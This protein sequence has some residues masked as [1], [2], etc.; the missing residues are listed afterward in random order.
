MGTAGEE[1]AEELIHRVAHG[2]YVAFVGGTAG[3]ALA[4][5][6]Q[7]PLARVLGAAAYGQFYLGVNLLTT[8]QW[9]ASLGLDWGVIRF[10]AQYRGAGD[11]RRVK[12]TL[13]S[14]VFI[15]M[16]S[17]T[18][19]AVLCIVFSGTLAGRVFHDPP[20]GRV[21]GMFALA[22]PFLALL[23]ITA[24]FAQSFH[25][26]FYM[27]ILQD[28]SQ[29]GITFLLVLL[30]LALGWGLTGAVFSVVAA[31]AA[32]ATLGSFLIF[33]LFPKIASPLAAIFSVRSL[34]RYSIPLM[35]LG[36]AWQFASR[37]DLWM[38]EYFV[39]ARAVGVYGAAATSALVLN[40]GMT[41]FAQ[42]TAPMMADLYHRRNLAELRWLFHTITRW[43]IVIVLSM[44]PVILILSAEIMRLFGREFDAGVMVLWLLALS[45]VVYFA[46]GPTAALMDM[47]GWQDLDLVNTVATGAVL[48]GLGVWLIPRYG[49]MGAAAA[50]SVSRVLLAVAE[51]VETYVLFKV[52]PFDARS[53]RP[54]GV[55]ALVAVVQVIALP[56]VGRFIVAG[57]GFGVY[58]LLGWRMCLSDHDRSV[59]K[60]VWRRV[61]APGVASVEGP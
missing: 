21:F 9:V 23:R 12:G 10:C 26:M 39:G 22:L 56:H 5:A 46:K 43:N 2:A 60:S 32:S 58:W 53:L 31:S 35:L 24:M 14:A 49:L 50:T 20:L 37:F 13:L 17:S 45:W 7:V 16:A 11:E 44:L 48:V 51:S 34:L 33:R 57:A 52:L 59:V 40:T 47:T 4:F 15:A 19:I 30:T 28:V 6:L 27:T 25:H 55:A 36:L 18:L 41:A 42:S 54:L 61:V 1:S 38:L 29:S 8:F 3:K